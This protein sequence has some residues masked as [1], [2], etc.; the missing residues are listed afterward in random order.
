MFVEAKRTMAATTALRPMPKIVAILSCLV[1]IYTSLLFKV[2]DMAFIKN[3]AVIQS[4]IPVPRI[5]IIP[6]IIFIFNASLYCVPTYRLI[7]YLDTH[8]TD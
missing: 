1:I 8:Y 3:A 2:T 6:L 4:E 7:N 5:I